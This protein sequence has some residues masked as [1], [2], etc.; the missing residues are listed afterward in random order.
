MMKIL[1]TGATGSVGKNLLPFLLQQYEDVEIMTLNRDQEK[2]GLLYTDRRIIN[3]GAINREEIHR[4]NPEYVIHLASFVTS[5]NDETVIERMLDANISYGVRLLDAL[6]G[7]PIRL[8]INFGTFAEYRLGADQIDN[9]YL[10]SASKSAFKRFLEYYSSLCGFAYVNVIP[11]T[12]Y[13]GIESQKKIIDYVYD[14]F[15]AEEPV[16]MTLGEQTLDLVHVSDLCSLMSFMLD[17]SE[18]FAASCRRDYF[19]GTGQGVRIRDLAQLMETVFDRKCNINWG[20]L[21]YRDRDVMHAVAQIGALV[22]MGWKPSVM[23]KDG[24]QIMKTEKYKNK[25]STR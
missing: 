8:F 15:D 5:S 12:I 9:A 24:L 4:F 6:R 23:L 22:D 10:Y 14:S 19:L 25:I 7:L 20:I 2:A 21:P 3:A 17:N 16:G 13:G 11:Y 18:R 1:I